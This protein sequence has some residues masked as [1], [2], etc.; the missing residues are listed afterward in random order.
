MDYAQTLKNH[1]LKVTPQRLAIVKELYDCGHLSIEQLYSKLKDIFPSISLAT[2]YK[3][4]NSM[5]E[6]IFVQ[7]VKIPNEKSVFELSKETHAH[8]V[9]NECKKIEDL[10]LN[11]SII[12]QELQNKTDYTITNTALVFNGVCKAC[13]K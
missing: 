10:F 4:M 6:K 11:T 2:I 13:S 3:N 7:E 8:I 1:N 5:V 12:M 9:C